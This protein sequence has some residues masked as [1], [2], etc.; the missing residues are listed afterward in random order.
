ML[1]NKIMINA[2]RIRDWNKEDIHDLISFFQELDKALEKKPNSNYPCAYRDAAIN[3]FDL[4][5]EEV[6]QNVGEV[7]PVWAMDKK[8]N[9]LM[10]IGFHNDKPFEVINIKELEA[11][12]EKKGKRKC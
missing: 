1:N 9:C 4:P 5:S 6:P 2:K 12:L 11:K 7:Y 3:I 10:N 8:G